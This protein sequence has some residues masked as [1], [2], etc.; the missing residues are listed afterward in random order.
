M[1]PKPKLGVEIAAGITTFLTMAYIIFV[2]SDILSATGMD[3]TGLIAATP[4]LLLC[5]VEL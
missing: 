1:T 2:N 3:K 4:D 5:D